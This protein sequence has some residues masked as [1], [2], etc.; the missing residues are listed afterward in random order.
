M[1]VPK[2][3]LDTKIINQCLCSFRLQ[4]EDSG[5]EYI[6]YQAEPQLPQRQRHSSSGMN[7][8]SATTKSGSGGITASSNVTNNGGSKN[9]L[10]SEKRMRREIANSNE[11]RRM[12]S[13]NAGFQNLRSLLPRHEG[14]KLSKV[15]Y[16][17]PQ[18]TIL[19]YTVL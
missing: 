13:I 4:L 12:Q 7:T 8:S 3:I 1:F 17:T 6:Q 10:E 5:G 18:H 11:R 16:A 15:S 9:L 14:D 2:F 19:Y